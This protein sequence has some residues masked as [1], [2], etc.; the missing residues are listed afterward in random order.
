LKMLWGSFILTLHPLWVQIS[1][2]GYDYEIKIK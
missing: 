2:Q 1:K